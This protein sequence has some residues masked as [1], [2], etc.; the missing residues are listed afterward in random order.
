[1]ATQAAYR[2]I[3]L[4]PWIFACGLCEIRVTGSEIGLEPEK[5]NY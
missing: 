1:M 4:R 3:L 5:Q 2:N